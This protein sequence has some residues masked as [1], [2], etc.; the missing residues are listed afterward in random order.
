MFNVRY[1]MAGR[2]AGVKK[3]CCVK[4]LISQTSSSVQ[5]TFLMGLDIFIAAQ[6]AQVAQPIWVALAGKLRQSKHQH[7]TDPGYYMV[8]WQSSSETHTK[9]T[10]LPSYVGNE[11]KL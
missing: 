7:K 6:I 1:T 3:R 4:D 8:R 9:H 5:E 11:M 2:D 10:R